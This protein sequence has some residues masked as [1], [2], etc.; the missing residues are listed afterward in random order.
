M[1]KIIYA[2]NVSLDGF[3]EDQHGKIEWTAPSKELHL[4]FNE[5]EKQIDTHLYG[6]NVYTIM[7]FWE[8]ADE[9]PEL[10]EYM[11]EYSRIWKQQK[12]IVFS[13]TLRSVDDSYDLRNTVDPKEINE[14]KSAPGKHMFLG[15]ANLAASFMR[16]RLL[17]EVHLYILPLLLGGGK[18]M[19]PSGDEQSLDLLESQPFPG[20]VVM[21]K[22]Q[23]KNE[24]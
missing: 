24:S 8:N 15:G 10:D 4:H 19:F 14:W 7:Q 13:T 11:K 2:E 17:D 6:R 21:L 9:N 18:P 12:K 16:H 3:I 23:I 5:R 1:R 20:G 22:Y